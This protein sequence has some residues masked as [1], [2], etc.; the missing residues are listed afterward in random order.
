MTDALEKCTPLFK[1]YFPS[2]LLEGLVLLGMLHILVSL[3]LTFIS[4]FGLAATFYA[5][6]V[7]CD[8]HLVPAVEVYIQ[9]LRIPEDIAGVTL[10]AFGSAAP[11]LFLN[12]V[13]AFENS[14]DLSLPAV[15]GSAIIAFGLIPSLC[16]LCTNQKE[17]NVQLS[18]WPII[19]ETSFYLFGL[20][21]F[22]MAIQD[23]EVEYEEA[24]GLI[25]V[26]AVYVGS[27]AGFYIMASGN[28]SSSPYSS[29]NNLRA[30]S[31]D[32]NA[33]LIDEKMLQTEIM[34]IENSL[35]ISSSALAST[36]II[37]GKKMPPNQKISKKTV[38]SPSFKARSNST[39]ANSLSIDKSISE[40]VEEL[41]QNT[42]T[43]Q[44][45]RLLKLVFKS[46]WEYITIP[47]S[48]VIDR[49]F[50][51]LTVIGQDENKKDIYSIKSA[52][53]S[54]AASV[55]GISVLAYL[56][57]LFT[58]LLVQ[59][60]GVGTTTVGATLVSLGAEIPDTMSSIAL[61]RSGHNDGAMAGAIGSQV[62][63]IT[64][65]VGLPALISCWLYGGSLVIEPDQM[66]RLVTIY[67]Y[68][69]MQG[70]CSLSHNCLNFTTCSLAIALR[71]SSIGKFVVAYIAG[72]HY[73][74]RLRGSQSPTLSGYFLQY[75]EVYDY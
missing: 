54:L 73:C 12:T 49:A 61:S 27:V 17:E 55:V 47:V 33:P 31:D 50:P 66:K 9:Q 41:P 14:S 11:E 18:A 64:L 26:Y 67:L 38:L 37:S 22:C 10:I 43:G 69:G 40:D 25:L 23:G 20:A 51:V 65:G 24:L 48:R 46:L 72:I 32:G 28:A 16:I 42:A 53:C 3:V 68:P 6:C 57:I 13:A 74:H 5:V 59:Q 19:R 45:F 39:T 44:D 35:P 4:S 70:L 75:H 8:S 56:I 15:L 2:Q 30:D 29:D 58:K 7:I 71:Y 34:T 52:A 62:I 1:T 60:I 36:V 63:N 21:T